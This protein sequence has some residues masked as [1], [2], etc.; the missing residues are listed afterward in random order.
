MT[1]YA[2]KRPEYLS[3]ISSIK[4]SLRNPNRCNQ[5]AKRWIQWRQANKWTIFYRKICCEIL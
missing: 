3:F 1:G 2:Q 5:L 4:P